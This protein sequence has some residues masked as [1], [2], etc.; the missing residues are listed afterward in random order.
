[1]YPPLKISAAIIQANFWSPKETCARP[2]RRS[3][4]S[5]EAI[6]FCG[7]AHCE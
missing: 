7:R 5:A 2:T 1:M 6:L 4:E 3:T